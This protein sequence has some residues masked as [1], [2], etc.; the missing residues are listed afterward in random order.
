MLFA[1]SPEWQI[2]RDYD[3]RIISDIEV[4]LKSWDSL[5]KCFDPTCWSLAK[6]LVPKLNQVSQ[7]FNKSPNRAHKLC[8][9]C[10]KFCKQGCQFEHS[11]PG[12]SCIFIHKCSICCGD[13][14][15]IYCTLED[16]L[17]SEIPLSQQTETSDT[18]F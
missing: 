7:N 1:N 9:T 13:H 11:N 10:N 8:T 2:G 5:K 14:K 16:D 6:E 17:S 4:G 18:F 12:Q 3:H 15:A